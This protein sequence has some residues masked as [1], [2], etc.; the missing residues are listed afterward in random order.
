M[1]SSTCRARLQVEETLVA[2]GDA[3]GAAHV[4]EDLGAVRVAAGRVVR[5]GATV[6]C[7]GR[8]INS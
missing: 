3:V 2:V 1:L 8:S 5:E 7:W 6:S 4:G